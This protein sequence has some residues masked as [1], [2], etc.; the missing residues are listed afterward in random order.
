MSDIWRP[1]NILHYRYF[2]HQFTH[3]IIAARLGIS[4]R[5]CFRDQDKAIELLL[6]ALLQLDALSF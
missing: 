2:K 3:D 1:Y 6:K 5:Q 4:R